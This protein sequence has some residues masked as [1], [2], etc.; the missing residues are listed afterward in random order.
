MGFPWRSLA[1]RVIGDGVADDEEGEVRGEGERSGGGEEGQAE[2]D[3]PIP[4]FSFG[5]KKLFD[6]VLTL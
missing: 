3:Y 4:M 1:G 5:P 2:F 6:C